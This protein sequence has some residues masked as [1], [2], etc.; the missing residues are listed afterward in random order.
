MVL[1]VSPSRLEVEVAA[2][3]EFSAAIVVIIVLARKIL[4]CERV[5]NLR[6]CR[7]LTMADFRI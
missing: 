5:K 4:V 3:E 7:N 1:H 6:D 2:A